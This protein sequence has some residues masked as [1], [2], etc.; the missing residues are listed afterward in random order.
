VSGRLIAIVALAA[1]SG[2]TP[3]RPP[4][5]PGSGSG[6]A[7]SPPP[8]VGPPPRMPMSH[9][10]TAEA[11]SPGQPGHADPKRSGC[12]A[13]AD[14]SEH[15]H[16]RCNARG[17]GHELARNDCEY[18]ACL[19]DADCG[20]TDVCECES[21]GNFCSHGACRTDAD[22]GAGGACSADRGCRGTQRGYFCHGANDACVDDDDC[23]KKD[24]STSCH[25]VPEVGHWACVKLQCPVG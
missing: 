5:T 18:D 20:K 7:P 4:A 2:G 21:T 9:R 25:Y 17:G 1:C 15:P 3:E 23:W 10:A 13:D 11:C 8:P 6:S 16:G 19:R 22:C 24:Q 12:K 14:C